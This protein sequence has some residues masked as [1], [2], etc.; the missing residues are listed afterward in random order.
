VYGADPVRVD[1]ANGEIREY[2]PLVPFDAALERV[3]GNVAMDHHR[4]FS[5]ETPFV[6]AVTW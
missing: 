4:P 1:L 2:P 5:F 3:I 6:D